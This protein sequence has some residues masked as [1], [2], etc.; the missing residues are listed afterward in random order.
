M[1]D[2]DWV[3]LATILIGLPG[4][5][6][7][8]TQHTVKLIENIESMG[9]KTFLVPLTFV[10]LGTCVLR[11]AALNSFN[12]LSEGQVDVF[13]SAWEHN[14]KVWGPDFFKSPPYTSYWAKLGFKLASRLLYN[15]KYKRSDKWR[16]AIANRIF[17]SLKQVI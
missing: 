12:D 3:A 9:L 14:I 11:D 2:Y 6:D 17:E 5:T 13:A 7:E 1:E 8:D 4:E 16:R 15:L 10:P